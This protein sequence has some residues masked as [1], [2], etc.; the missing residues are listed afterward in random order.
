MFY[1]AQTLRTAAAELG[2]WR[3]RFLQD[4]EDLVK[5][6]PLAHSAFRVKISAQAVYLRQAPFNQ[7]TALW[8]HPRDY[9]A[10]QAFAQVARAAGLGA[11][12]YQS[13]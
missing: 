10:T 6:E 12:Q 2:Y 1:A 9:H 7:D 11:I 8:L 4:A 13:V 3:W 5:L